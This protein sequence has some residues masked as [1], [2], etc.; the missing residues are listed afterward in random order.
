MINKLFLL[1]LDELPLI[2][3]IAG[4][5]VVSC[6]AFLISK[7]IGLLITGLMLIAVALLL[8]YQ[9]GSDQ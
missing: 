1:F 9:K 6:G 3:L 5:V 7:I 8:A 4:I 2:L